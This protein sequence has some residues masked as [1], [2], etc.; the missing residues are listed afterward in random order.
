MYLGFGKRNGFS[1]RCKD[2]GISAIFHYS[3]VYSL[4]LG[5]VHRIPFPPSFNAIPSSLFSFL[6]ACSYSS[7]RQNLQLQK[8]MASISEMFKKRAKKLSTIGSRAKT[9]ISSLPLLNAIM[10]LQTTRKCI[11]HFW[12]HNHLSIQ[13]Y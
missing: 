5:N 10:E 11:A 2:E 1:Y 3:L 8:F 4:L 13:I 12:H 7:H 9:R 6:K